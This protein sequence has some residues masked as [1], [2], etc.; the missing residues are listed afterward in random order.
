MATLNIQVSTLFMR[1]AHRCDFSP[2]CLVR[3]RALDKAAVDRMA[4]MIQVN[5]KKET[6]TL[7]DNASDGGRSEDADDCDDQIDDNACVPLVAA[8]IETWGGLVMRS[9]EAGCSLS[10]ADFG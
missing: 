10:A 2:R 8:S 6:S 7:Q 5:V 1:L 3:R 9:S 4:S